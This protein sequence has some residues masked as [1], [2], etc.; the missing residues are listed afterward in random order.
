M[1][2]DSKWTISPLIRFL[3]FKK[4]DAVTRL[5]MERKLNVYASL[6]S[7]MIQFVFEYAVK[8]KVR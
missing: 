3:Q 8:K 5:P 7:D 1:R 4:I 2:G 6:L